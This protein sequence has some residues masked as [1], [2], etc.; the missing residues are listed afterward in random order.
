[1]MSLS[2]I[3]N[4]QVKQEIKAS[5]NYGN[6][7]STV[8]EKVGIDIYPGATKAAM[9]NIKSGWGDWLQCYNTLGSFWAI[10]NNDKQDRVQVYLN[11]GHDNIIWNVL[12]FNN[13]GQVG[14]G[15][16]FY[17]IDSKLAV[18]GKIYARE[19]EVNLNTWPDDVFKPEYKL[20]TLTDLEKFI[21]QNSHLPGIPA[22]TEV[23]ENGLN[24][25][26]MNAK[27]LQKVEELTL[28]VIEL[29]K[30]VEQMKDSSISNR[31]NQ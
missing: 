24:L 29:K 14:I 1:M 6:R 13:L 12:S 2:S 15:T 5:G 3:V 18:D 17:P 19:I 30:E 16:G 7:I 21:N 10:H 9:L 28:Y 23:L 4:G 27:L 22:E 8:N 31:V 11:D 20:M 26:D 25:G